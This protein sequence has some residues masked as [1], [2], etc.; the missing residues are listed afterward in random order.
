MKNKKCSLALGGG[1]FRWFIHIWVLKYLEEKNIEIVELAGASMWAIVASLIAVWK[2]SD[3]ITKIAK[4]INFVRLIDVDLSFWFIKWKKVLKKLEELFWE[5]RIEDL[6]IP[7]KIVATNVE[8]GGRKIFTEWRIAD[9]LRASL[10]LPWIFIPYK[11]WDSY[12]IDG[13]VVN[14]LPVDVLKWENIIWVSA[15]K[16]MKWPL[17]SKTKI[18]GFEMKA[19]FFKFN[20]QIMRRMIL[21]MMKQNETRSIKYKKNAIIIRPNFWDLDFQDYNKVDEF[22]ELGYEAAK[23]KL[24][25]NG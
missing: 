13:W 22:V 7:L 8:T 17:T 6:K 12:Y 5:I 18:L 1:S 24:R 21:Y 19:S 11:I 20:S 14:N 2:N 9:A 4:S 16:N 10:S 25:N 23:K 3:D 15:L